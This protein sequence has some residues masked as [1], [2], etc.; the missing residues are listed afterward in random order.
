MSCNTF[1]KRIQS[2]I[3]NLIIFFIPQKLLNFRKNEKVFFCNLPIHG[4]KYQKFPQL[5]TPITSNIKTH[6]P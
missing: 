6:R 4:H 3:A 2:C 1:S 5:I